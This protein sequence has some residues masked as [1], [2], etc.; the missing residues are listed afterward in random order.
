MTQAFNLGQLAN[1]VNTSGQLDASTGLVNTTAV[2][3]GGTGQASLTTGTVLLGNGTSAVNMY[4]GTTTNDAL[5]WNG[6]TWTSAPVS[7]VGGGGGYQMTVRTSPSS[8]TKP[9]SLKAVKI[10]VIG[11][12]GSSGANATGGLPP[13]TKV[14]GSGGGGGSSIYYAP[15]PTLPA[16]AITVTAGAGTNSFGAFVSCTAGSNGTPAT[17]PVGVPGTP[18]AGGTAT[19]GAVNVNGGQ[20]FPIAIGFGGQTILG[21][22]NPSNGTGY[23]SGATSGTGAS[24]KAGVVIIEEFF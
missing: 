23:G 2:A 12:G 19:G 8:Y 1:K 24:G 18:G 17:G 13:S 20:G 6:S 16:S 21:F 11:G 22:G 9:A 5:I 14:G 10:T 15:A 3:N 4:A 7:S